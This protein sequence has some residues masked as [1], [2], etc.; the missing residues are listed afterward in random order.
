MR[1]IN[2]SVH[3]APIVEA[4]WAMVTMGTALI[5][6][7]NV[8]IIIINFDYYYYYY[9]YYHHYYYHYHYYYYYRIEIKPRAT[10]E[11]VNQP[12]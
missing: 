7:L 9:Y 6:V 10:N 11:I 12:T 5:K 1:A 4:L 3:V 2:V 8:I